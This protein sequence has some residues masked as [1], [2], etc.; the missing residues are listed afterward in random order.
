M[1]YYH[2]INNNKRLGYG[3]DRIVKVG[4]TYKVGC[5]PVLCESGLHASK[6]LID[7]LRYAPGPILC[8]VELGGT[9]IFGDDKVVATERT[10]VAMAD[11]S[12]I[13]RKFARLCALDV[14]HLW[15]APE[16]VRKF[17]KTGDESLR[18]AAWAAARD[19]AWG[20]ARDAAWAA[21]WDAARDAVRAVAAARNAARDADAAV[22][23]A[24]DAARD[25]AR[26]TTG[27]VVL[28]GADGAGE[29]QNRRLVAM[30]RKADWKVK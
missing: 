22:A 3:D 26:A 17:L 10:V 6:R 4:R 7:A 14:I 29:K 15:E 30:I 2:F 21:A 12:E 28:A 20:A 24:W 9:I 18:A 11:V 1:T 16:V 25:A 13:L 5:Q 19:A 27:D 23:A 8:K